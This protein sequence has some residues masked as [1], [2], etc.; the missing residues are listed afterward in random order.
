M[1]K[2]VLGFVFG[3]VTL[4]LLQSVSA[5]VHYEY[6]DNYRGRLYVGFNDDHRYGRYYGGDID[7]ERYCRYWDRGRLEWRRDRVCEWVNKGDWKERTQRTRAAIWQSNSF[8]NRYNLL[9]GQSSGDAFYY[10]YGDKGETKPNDWRYKRVY[11][12]RIDNEYVMGKGYYYYKPRID[13]ETGT[14]SWR[15]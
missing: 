11:D 2:I 7:E 15:F 5:Y 1:R 13:K 6:S 14:Y 10:H 3:L 12:P 4:M 9:G 8:D